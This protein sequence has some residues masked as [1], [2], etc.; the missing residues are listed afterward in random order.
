[1]KPA[2]PSPSLRRTGP[3]AV[4]VGHRGASSLVAENTLPAFVAAWDAGAIWVEAD[5]QPSGDGVP[6]ILHD[7]DL[8]RTTSGSG[9]VRGHSAAD[10]AA[11]DVLG[12]RGANV[13]ELGALLAALTPDRAVLLEIKGGHSAEQVR[14]VID[15][16]EACG[17]PERVFLQS[18]EVTALRHLKEIAPT[19]PFGL[20]VE[21][22]DA[23]PVARSRRLGAVAYNPRF[24]EVLA[25]PGIVPVLRSAGITVA[26]WT[27]DDPAEWELL[28]V[29]GVDA[30]I[31]NTPAELLAW[32]AARA[33]R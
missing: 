10:I 7:D 28:T 9:P 1:M 13:P 4:V 16:A 17:Y 25:R 30:I 26:V 24:G 2:A 20:L 33:G 12:L 8:D 5:T 6:V 22:L 21:R 23:D 3:D 19:R 27:S 32:Q 29:A 11:L 18:F 15:A 14:S 31:T